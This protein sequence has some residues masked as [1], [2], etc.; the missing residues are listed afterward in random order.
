MKNPINQRE[1]RLLFQAVSLLGQ[2]GLIMVISV[3]L[4]V[5]LGYYIDQW[6]GW[7]GVAIAV[8]SLLGILCGGAVDWKLLM[9][10]F[11]KREP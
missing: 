7:N 4:F 9:R 6:L 11:D 1:N 2:L 3:L 10:F 5:I 8:C